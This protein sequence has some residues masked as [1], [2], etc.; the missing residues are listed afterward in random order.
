[1]NPDHLKY[2]VCPK[3]QQPL[4]IK[5][6]SVVENKR[7]KEGVLIEP[8]AHRE[9]PIVNFIPRFVTQ[10]NYAQNFGI[11]WNIHNL[12]QYDEFSG[13]SVS[14]ERFEKETKWEMDLRGET[15]LEV[16]SGSG[17]F[18]KYAL[19]TGAFVVSLDYSEAVEANYTS[20]GAHDSLLL[21][22][23]SVYEMPF[24]NN[25][26]DRAFCFGVLQH[27]PDPEKS[28]FSI[29]EHIR[30]NGQIASDVYVKDIRHW[31]LQTKYWVR[32]FIRKD[33][34]AKLYEKTKRHVD[35]LWPLA[36]IV[37]K[38][39]SIGY[40]INWRLLVADYSKVLPHA[41]DRTL[42]EWA[43][44]DTYDMLSPMYDKPQ[45]LK[46]FKRWHEAAGL[47]DIEVHYGYNGIEGRGRKSVK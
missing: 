20:N 31:L 22:Q 18:T 37:R 14:K 8:I 3:T 41:D 1:M 10:N 4:E 26:F 47:T 46:T 39:P 23:A 6:S 42:K 33:N 40:A 9:Y 12:T 36:R 25:F 21:V 13:F 45:T 24:K 35:F 29:V 15:I 11:E 19:A 28:F 34:P 30:P 2:L 43:Y 32:P 17:R 44:L 16:G 7:I 5:S 27:T 38:I